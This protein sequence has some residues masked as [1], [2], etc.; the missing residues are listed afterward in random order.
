LNALYHPISLA[1][2]DSEVKIYSVMARWLTLHTCLAIIDLAVRE[3]TSSIMPSEK[4]SDA[5]LEHLCPR[6]RIKSGIRL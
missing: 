3:N 2:I 4:S 5:E 6:N 1:G